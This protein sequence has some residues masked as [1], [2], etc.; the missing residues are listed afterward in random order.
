MKFSAAI[1]LLI[2]GFY[3]VQPILK[4]EAKESSKGCCSKKKCTK[5]MP[6]QSKRSSCE[7]MACNLLVGCPFN[8][9]YYVSNKPVLTFILP[10][11]KERVFISNDNR[12]IKCITECWHPPNG[13]F[14]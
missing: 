10:I 14:I 3:S 5:K 7:G 6:E 12:T 4:V 1:L 2:L 13:T 9:L 11:K 8:A